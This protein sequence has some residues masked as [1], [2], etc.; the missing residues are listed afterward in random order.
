MSECIPFV[1]VATPGW[2]SSLRP[3]GQGNSHQFVS[4]LNLDLARL[5]FNFMP[6]IL[7]QFPLLAW[8]FE[9]S[10]VYIFIIDY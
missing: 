1:I 6:C 5:G 4:L 3:E 9:V 8:H 7:A 10:W 2:F